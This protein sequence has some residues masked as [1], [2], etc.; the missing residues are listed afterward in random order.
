MVAITPGHLPD[1]G[2]R[3]GT[4][5]S[6]LNW[7]ADSL[8]LAPPGKL[9]SKYGELKFTIEALLLS[10]TLNYENHASAF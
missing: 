1:Q 2:W 4:H 3:D 10:V 5:V 6:C 8:P 7:Q 9:A